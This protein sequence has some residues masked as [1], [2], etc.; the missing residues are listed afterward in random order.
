[1]YLYMLILQGVHPLGDVNQGWCGK[2]SYFQDKCIII[3]TTVW[4]ISTV[5]VND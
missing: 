4:D 2:T 1:M 5:T 3:S